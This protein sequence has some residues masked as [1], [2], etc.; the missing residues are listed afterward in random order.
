MAGRRGWD[1]DIE[2]KEAGVVLSLG[3][4][5]KASFDG[6]RVPGLPRDLTLTESQKWKRKDEPPAKA[7][8]ELPGRSGMGMR[9]DFFDEPSLRGCSGVLGNF[10]M[11]SPLKTVQRE[12][13]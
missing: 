11:R 12:P 4:G 13:R 8:R 2:E 5:G 3:P 6:P 1:G 7:T 10:V 9:L